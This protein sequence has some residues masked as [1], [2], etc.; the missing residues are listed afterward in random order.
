MGRYNKVI[1]IHSF[2]PGWLSLT[3]VQRIFIMASHPVQLWTA[4]MYV[5]V[6]QTEQMEPELV[7]GWIKTGSQWS[8]HVAFM[9][10]DQ[11]QRSL[12]KTLPRTQLV[13][14]TMNTRVQ[15]TCIHVYHRLDRWCTIMRG[16]KI[17]HTFTFINGKLRISIINSLNAVFHVPPISNT[18]PHSTWSD[19]NSNSHSSL[20]HLL[21]ELILIVVVMGE[22]VDIITFT[23]SHMSILLSFVFMDTPVFNVIYY[24]FYM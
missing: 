10:F 15:P 7:P 11:E 23:Q 21:P 12:A 1:H 19:W 2:I 17:M 9:A 8:L 13:Y 22:R 18:P 24:N 3:R 5:C 20:V 6:P 4:V 16:E 14:K